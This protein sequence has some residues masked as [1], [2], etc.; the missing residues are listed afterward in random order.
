MAP[1]PYLRKASLTHTIAG[2]ESALERAGADGADLV[3]G[4]VLASI[5]RESGA[6]VATLDRDFNRF[7]DIQVVRSGG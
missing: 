1:G 3:P 6:Q 4:A 2:L 7:K 5:A